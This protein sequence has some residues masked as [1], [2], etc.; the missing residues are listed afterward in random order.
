LV[1]FQSAL[2]PLLY[3]HYKEKETPEKIAY[4]FHLYLLISLFSLIVLS[5]SGDGLVKLVAGVQYVEA[6]NYVVPLV[7]AALFSSMYIFFPGLSIAKKTSTIATVNI[8]AGILNVILNYVF[9][10][11]FGALGASFSTLLSISIALFCNALFSQNLYKIPLNYIFI[12]S[13]L[14]VFLFLFSLS[15]YNSLFI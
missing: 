12:F 10:P 5:I 9:I 13:I 4:L 3:L 14:C 15:L 1:G 6:A 11:K 7:C 2:T 8:I